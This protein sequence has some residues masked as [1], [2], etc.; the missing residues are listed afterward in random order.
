[1]QSACRTAPSRARAAVTG[2][3]KPIYR[4]GSRYS[5]QTASVRIYNGFQSFSITV[6]VR[7]PLSGD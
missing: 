7:T 6:V 2:Y 4:N 1:M 5:S 3:G